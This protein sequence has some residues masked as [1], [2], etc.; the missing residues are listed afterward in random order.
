M[1]AF[2]TLNHNVS[3]SV[4]YDNDR[5]DENRLPENT[6]DIELIRDIA[7]RSDILY[8]F[9]ESGSD[10]RVKLPAYLGPVLFSEL[11]LFHDQGIIGVN[12]DIA[13][14][15]KLKPGARAWRFQLDASQEDVFRRIAEVTRDNILT[16]LPNSPWMESAERATTEF[17]E[18]RE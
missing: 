12:R 11:S 3:I 2:L 17:F 13:A 14:S 15:K 6:S 4:A 1:A 5:M 9:N 7:H 10:W 16:L 18:L 8:L